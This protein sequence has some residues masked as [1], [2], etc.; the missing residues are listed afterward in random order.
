MLHVFWGWTNKYRHDGEKELGF[1][2][3][4][5]DVIDK[6]D[7]KPRMNSMVMGIWKVFVLFLQ[8][9]YRSKIILK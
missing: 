4:E 2:P 5:G 3:L 9:V 8:L 6:K 1:S 7:G